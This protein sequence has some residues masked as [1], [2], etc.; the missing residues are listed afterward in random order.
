MVLFTRCFR[1][2]GPSVWKMVGVLS[3]WTLLRY[4]MDTP[5][6][7]RTIQDHGGLRPLDPES[8][9]E[10]EVLEDP[11]EAVLVGLTHGGKPR[12]LANEP[13]RDQAAGESVRLL[14]V[15]PMS[16]A[17]KRSACATT[18]DSCMWQHVQDASVAYSRVMSHMMGPNKESL[19][20]SIT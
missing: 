9:S 6:P 7:A 5:Q 16:R 20:A 4:L 12:A 14:R 3:G 15:F 1:S 18:I 10:A 8:E 19:Y 13:C 17:G 2:V 11:C